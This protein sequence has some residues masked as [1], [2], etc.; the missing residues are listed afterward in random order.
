MNI[1]LTLIIP[2]AVGDKEGSSDFD[3]ILIVGGIISVLYLSAVII[4]T[5]YFKWT[6]T[7]FLIIAYS[8]ILFRILGMIV[9]WLTGGLTEEEKK[10]PEKEEPT[11][12]EK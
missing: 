11:P 6:F 10:T 9:I 3:S 4:V 12:Q 2:T 1:I 5:F 8:Y 7:T